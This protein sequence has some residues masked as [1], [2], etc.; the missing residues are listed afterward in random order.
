MTATDELRRLLDDRG[1][2][3]EKPYAGNPEQW[4]FWGGVCCA[5][6]TAYGQVWLGMSLTPEQAIEA[7]LGRGTCT[8]VVDDHHRV[9]KVTTS[10]GCV[11][12]S[13]GIFHQY[14]HGEGWTFCPSCGAKVVRE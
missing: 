6:E 14:S 11:C 10:W 5:N 4:T 13:C 8:M 2:E 1:I 3:W 12:S 7:T 9:D